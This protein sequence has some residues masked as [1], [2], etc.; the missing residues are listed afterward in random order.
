MTLGL[1]ASVPCAGA[2]MLNNVSNAVL[3]PWPI[4]D[5]PELRGTV[6]LWLFASE[7]KMCRLVFAP[8]TPTALANVHS[9][10]RVQSPAPT[11]L[12]LTK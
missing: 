8:I 1:V 7:M 2:P 10:P 11:A 12:L 3:T 9:A 6:A 5:A 4:S